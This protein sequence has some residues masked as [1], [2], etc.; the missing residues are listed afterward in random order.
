MPITKDE[1][2]E[3]LRLLLLDLVDYC[4][5]RL[6]SPD[7]AQLHLGLL[8]IAAGGAFEFEMTRKE[9]LQQAAA[10]YDEYTFASATP[11]NTP[12]EKG[13]LS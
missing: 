6:P 13:Q 2:P 7:V 9:F 8:A 3:E 4:A 5:T 1:L 12:V 10:F 11:D